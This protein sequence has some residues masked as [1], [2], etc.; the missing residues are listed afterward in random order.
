M[1][2]EVS[3]PHA[4][5]GFHS[6][7][8]LARRSGNLLAVLHPSLFVELRRRTPETIRLGEQ[9]ELFFTS[10]QAFFGSVALPGHPTTGFACL[11]GHAVLSCPV[12]RVLFAP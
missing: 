9:L 4:Y 7:A 3:L 5:P 12:D 1:Y 2:F 11:T 8:R 10:R 6:C